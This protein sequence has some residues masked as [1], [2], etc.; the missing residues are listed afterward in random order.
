MTARWLTIFLDLPRERADEA[1]A[2]WAAVTGSAV[3]PR[4]GTSG[5]FATLLPPVGDPWLR[6][7]RVAAGAGGSHLDVHVESLTEA[8]TRAV[9][10]GARVVRRED[11]V[12]VLASPGRLPFCVVPWAGERAVAEQRQSDGARLDQLCLD[13]PLP[14]WEQETVF[15]RDLLGAA[16]RTGARPEFAYLERSPE[17]VVRLL[18]QRLDEAAPGQPV[19]AHV[20]FACGD[21]V[22]EV[23][24]THVALGAVVEH[25]FRYWTVLVVPTGR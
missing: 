20:D 4:R 21:A 10:L 7:Q 6:V 25:A 16:L 12:I 19:G 24:A 14:L 2:F 17:H 13:V 3:S 11:D 18:F 9:S 22:D 8:A 5:E 23:A 1:E 15:W